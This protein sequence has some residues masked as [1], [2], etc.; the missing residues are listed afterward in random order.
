[1]LQNALRIMEAHRRSEAD[2][3]NET[4]IEYDRTQIDV[5]VINNSL[6]KE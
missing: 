3:D 6:S 1:M 2:A 5:G 4:G